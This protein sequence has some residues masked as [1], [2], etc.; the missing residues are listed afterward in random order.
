M[1]GNTKEYFDFWE[2]D[3]DPTNAK[4][5]CE[6]LLNKVKDCARRRKLDTTAKERMQQ[7]GDPMDAGAVGG[8]SCRMASTR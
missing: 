3:H 5:T 2:A 7:L 8:W 6:D 1:A 4:K